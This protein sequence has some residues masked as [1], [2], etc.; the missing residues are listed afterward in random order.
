ML[1]EKGHNVYVRNAQPMQG[2]PRGRAKQFKEE[3]KK[4]RKNRVEETTKIKR[5][6]KCLLRDRSA[7]ATDHRI[8]GAHFCLGRARS[9]ADSA[10]SLAFASDS[11]MRPITLIAVQPVGCENSQPTTDQPEVE[12]N[13]AIQ[14]PIFRNFYNTILPP[15]FCQL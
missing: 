8:G 9:L 12:I 13:G 1:H 15:I 14:S 2:S 3:V 5:K 11:T 10:H 6:K 4:K 7:G